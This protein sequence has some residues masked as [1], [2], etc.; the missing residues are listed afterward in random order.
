[1]ATVPVFLFIIV[2]ESGQIRSMDVGFPT[3]EYLSATL[4]VDQERVPSPDSPAQLMALAAA[5][6]ELERRLEAEPGVTAVTFADRLP[7]MSHPRRRIEVDRGVV[8]SSPSEDVG[9]HV[10]RTAAAAPDFF[11]ALDA[12]ILSGRGFHSGNLLPSTRSVIVNQSF[13]RLILGGSNPIGRRLRYRPLEDGSTS[14]SEPWYEIVGVVRDMG[15]A[16]RAAASGDLSSARSGR[17]LARPHCRPYE[18]RSIGLRVTSAVYRHGRRSDT[19]APRHRPARSS[20][21]G[22]SPHLH[23]VLLDH[24]SHDVGRLAPVAHGGLYDSLLRRLAANA[25]SGD[26]HRARCQ[27]S[28]RRGCNLSSAAG[29]GRPGYLDRIGIRERPGNVQWCPLR[30]D[31][32]LRYHRNMRAGGSQA[33][34]KH[35]PHPAERGVASGSVA[36]CSSST[37]PTFNAAVSGDGCETDQLVEGGAQDTPPVGADRSADSDLAYAATA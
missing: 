25:R 28:T 24:H 8:A 26:S 21:R 23:G 30:R 20:H 37:P 9:A 34:T 4:V 33:S 17:K 16:F 35:T 6:P 29:T 5:Y 11:D 15:M 10:V 14:T 1:M 18:K 27:A 3:E 19:S 31:V 13:V 2:R 12:P 22:E 7:L 36:T 32:R